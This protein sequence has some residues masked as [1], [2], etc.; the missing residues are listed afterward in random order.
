MACAGDMHRRK[1]KSTELFLIPGLK[2]P[3][4]PQLYTT[5][6]W[7]TPI[8]PKL[9]DTKIPKLKLGMRTAQ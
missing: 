1:L 2:T 9:R 3:H 5:R 8:R 6:L 7:I 4:S